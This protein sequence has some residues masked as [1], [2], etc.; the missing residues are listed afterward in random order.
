MAGGW[1]G[2]RIL[3]TVQHRAL[4]LNLPFWKGF[5]WDER[6]LCPERSPQQVGSLC[7]GTLLLVAPA[8]LFHASSVASRCPEQV[9]KGQVNERVGF[10][11]AGA[12][13]KG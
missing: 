3:F 5:A 13:Q 8:V 10:V 1:G 11:S 7:R 2:D 4:V 6:V 12:V 9:M